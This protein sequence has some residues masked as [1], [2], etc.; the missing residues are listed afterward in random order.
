M[1]TVF[2]VRSRAHGDGTVHEFLQLRR[3][4][5][6]YMGGTYQ[7]IRGGMDAGE[8]AIAA[9]LR[10][11][12]EESG[13]TPIEFYRL[14]SV[15]SFYIPAD[16]V[17]WHCPAFCAVVEPSAKPVLNDE[18]DGFRWVVA[19]QAEAAFMWSSE[20]RLID[21]IRR[22]ILDDGPAKPFLRLDIESSFT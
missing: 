8:S 4:L 19:E 13:L 10:E 5:S 9:A 12:R 6:D 20:W 11:L 17:I 22:V 15:E 2:V 21:E 18:H 14:G 7:T 16:D 3:V 1:V